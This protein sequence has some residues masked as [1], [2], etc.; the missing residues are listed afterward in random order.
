MREKDSRFKNESKLVIRL[1]SL[2]ESYKEIMF[3]I[4]T[5]FLDM[6]K[7]V[8]IFKVSDWIV[9]FHTPGGVDRDGW[10]Y[11]TDFPSQYHGKKQFTDYVRRRRWFRRC[12]LTTSGPWQELGNTKLVDV[13][14]YVRFFTIIISKDFERNTCLQYFSVDYNRRLV[15]LAQMNLFTSGRLPQTERLYSDEVFQNLVQWY[16]YLNC[17]CIFFVTYNNADT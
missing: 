7:Y 13:S 4:M 8:L 11:A 15:S 16:Y 10:Q 12:Q 14:L 9:D 2:I 6:N 3:I 5:H 17:T 1:S